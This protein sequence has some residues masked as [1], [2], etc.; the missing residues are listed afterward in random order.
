MSRGC[1][2]KEEKVRQNLGI[3]LAEFIFDSDEI[4]NTKTKDDQ[5]ISYFNF[6]HSQL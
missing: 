1:L 3:E 5:V 2:E 4:S 6:L